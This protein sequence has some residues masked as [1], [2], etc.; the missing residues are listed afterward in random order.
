VAARRD[1]NIVRDALEGV[2]RRLATGDSGELVAL[3]QA[4]TRK[5][6]APIAVSADAASRLAADYSTLMHRL[7]EARELVDLLPELI[8][9]F[10]APAL[11]RG[12]TRR[13]PCSWSRSFS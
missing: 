3:F 10:G 1:Q 12:S 7:G 8:A 13:R 2:P 9:D 6:Y 4:L 5:W 11:L